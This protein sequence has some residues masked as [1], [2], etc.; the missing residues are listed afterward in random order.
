VSPVRHLAANITHRGAASVNGARD[1][2]AGRRGRSRR[3]V[4]GEGLPFVSRRWRAT[5]PFAHGRRP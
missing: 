3:I 2:A 1:V 5:L 4:A